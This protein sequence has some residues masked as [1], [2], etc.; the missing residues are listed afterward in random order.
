MV[1]CVRA[2]SGEAFDSPSA[3]LYS[4]GAQISCGLKVLTATTSDLEH[5]IEFSPS[6][7]RCSKQSVDV[8]IIPK[9][10]CYPNL[11]VLYM[12]RRRLLVWRSFRQRRVQHVAFYAKTADM[13]RSA[14]FHTATLCPLAELSFSLSFIP[15]L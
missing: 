11:Y 15:L 2:H 9:D 10:I 3:E 4:L 7:R 1:T 13:Q 6:S 14:T 12:N 5:R 8:T